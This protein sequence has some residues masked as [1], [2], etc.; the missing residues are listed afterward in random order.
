V[1]RGSVPGPTRGLGPGPRLPPKLGAP[2]GATT[3][4]S[5]SV[6]LGP[7]QAWGQPRLGAAQGRAKLPWGVHT[8][9][10]SSA[11][12]CKILQGGEQRETR[13]TPTGVRL[14]M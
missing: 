11:K 1:R 6:S 9:S 7:G 5:S 4:A 2:G 10:V 3:R 8:V 12:F 14:R 13:E